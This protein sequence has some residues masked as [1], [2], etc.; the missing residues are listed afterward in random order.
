M[1]KHILKTNPNLNFDQKNFLKFYLKELSKLTESSCKESNF[2][3]FKFLKFSNCLA[4]KDSSFGFK[5]INTGFLLS[6]VL[7]LSSNGHFMF[8]WWRCNWIKN[9]YN[10]LSRR[11][12]FIVNYIS[13]HQV[14]HNIMLVT[15][16]IFPLLQCHTIPSCLQFSNHFWR[17]L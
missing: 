9:K 7:A 13:K 3:P 1:K 14:P 16:N 10:N 6:N 8:M 11:Q 5:F 15:L 2:F 12:Y 17:L 4:G